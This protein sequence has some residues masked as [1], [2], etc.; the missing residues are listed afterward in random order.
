MANRQDRCSRTTPRKVRILFF[1][2]VLRNP[3]GLPI[4]I[5][6]GKYGH[7][8]NEPFPYRRRCHRR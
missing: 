2:Y 5:V 3:R 4:S 8:R 6:I 1:G 7:E